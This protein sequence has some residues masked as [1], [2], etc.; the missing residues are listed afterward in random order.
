MAP[1]P[2]PS[3]LTD[4]AILASLGRRIAETR[5]ARDLTQAE[6][7]KEA[8]V[9]KRTL[10]RLEGGESTQLTNLIRVLRALGLTGNLDALVPSPAPSPLKQLQSE[11]KQRKRA[12]GR[13]GAT[14]ATPSEG[15]E[16]WTWGDDD[17]DA[18]S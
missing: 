1:P 13:S 5:L 14:G 9:S 15:D 12:S 7:A 8:G 16:A 11:E 4:S 6:L 17:G 3:H 2:I 10:I 18:E